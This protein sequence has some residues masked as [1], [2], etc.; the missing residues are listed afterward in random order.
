M[1]IQPDRSQCAY[2]SIVDCEICARIPQQLTHDID[3]GYPHIIPPEAELLLRL[4]E[5]ND[6]STHRYC[7]SLTTLLKCPA[8]GT[9]Y[10]HNHYDDD[11]E[12]FMDPPSDRITLRR[13]DAVTAI[14]F[15]E[16]IAADPEGA[17]PHAMGRLTKAFMDGSGL[18]ATRIPD[19]GLADIQQAVKRE[20]EEL[21]LRYDLL[22][23][24]LIA[25]IQ[26]RTLNWHLKEYIMASVCNHYY[27]R[28]DW[29][30]PNRLLLHHPD[31][32]VRMLTARL[33]MGVGT[34]DAPVMDIIHACRAARE[35]L[36]GQVVTKPRMTELTGLLVDLALNAKG[37]TLQY[38]HGYGDSKYIPRSIRS[39]AL[40][41]LVVAAGRR[42]DLI[43][44]IPALVGLLIPIRRQKPGRT[45]TEA[46][47]QAA[48]DKWWAE[49]RM[50]YE[51]CWV[52]SELAHRK[53]RAP[54][55]IMAE[56]EKIKPPRR[57]LILKDGH[58][59]ELVEL[60]EKKLRKYA[61][62]RPV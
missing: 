7:T 31:P 13:Y 53:R 38:D 37:D 45:S 35:F 12:F 54:R 41:Y 56:I 40:Y 62:S 19:A 16:R 43:W 34:G 44:A 27:S 39:I 49:Q 47:K 30:S 22:I 2:K 15:M 52:L 20:L 24:D 28:Q 57:A 36:E 4:V 58:V 32:E 55:A 1:T 23:E 5:L 60:C 11:G 25:A 9:Y 14:E 48:K 18:D 10:Y 21:K 17:L 8:C 51:A 42:V 50:N 6:E 26:Q 3:S 33:V 59:Q 29:D 46:D 61:E